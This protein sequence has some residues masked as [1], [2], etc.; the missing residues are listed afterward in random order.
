MIPSDDRATAIDAHYG[1][2]DDLEGRILAALAAMG[3]DIEALTFTDLAPVD[4]FHTGGIDASRSLAQLAGVKKDAIVLDIGGGLGGPARMLA[5]EFG[6]SVTVLDLTES[7]VTTGAALTTRLGMERSVRFRHGD[8]LAMTFPNASFDLAWTQHATMNIADKDRLYAEI[9]RVL[10]RGARLAFHEVMAG[11][12]GPPHFPVPWASDPSI[13]SLLPPEEIRG[14]LASLGFVEV[15]WNDVTAEALAWFQAMQARA[16]AEPG[17][18]PFGLSLV[19]GADFGQRFA[20]MGRNL[21]E[22][23]VTVIQA[24]FNRS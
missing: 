3:K 9:A 15:A 21:A 24:V 16:A 23:R 14:L 22:D 7:F 6:A 8:A 19:L 11:P 2:T 20:S 18:P 17:P 4:Q 1:K 12:G 10:R 5:E 13:S